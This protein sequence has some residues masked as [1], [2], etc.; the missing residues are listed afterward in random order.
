[1]ENGFRLGAEALMPCFMAAPPPQCNVV[2]QWGPY[3]LGIKALC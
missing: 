1:M 2:Q 3:E